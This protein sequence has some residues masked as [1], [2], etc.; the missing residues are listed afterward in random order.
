MKINT[1]TS[2]FHILLIILISGIVF[3]NTF[4]NS[5]VYD[6]KVFIVNNES[7]KSL[8]N[9]P[10]FFISAK[11]FSGERNF[12]V[13]RPVATLSFAIDYFLWGLNPVGYHIPN[14]L[15]HTLNAILLYFLVR[16]ILTT[17]M[18]A[19][20]ASLL[21][22]THPV[23]TEAVTWI[24]GRSNV[25]FLF[26]FLLAF[27]FYLKFVGFEIKCLEQTSNSRLYYYFGA[28]VFFILSLLS[29]ETAIIFPVILILYDNFLIPKKERKEVLKQGQ[30]YLPFWGVSGLYILLRFTVLGRISQMGF[31]GGGLY[32][33]ILTMCRA[34]VYYIKLILLPLKLSIDYPF[35][36]STSFFELPVI[37]SIVGLMFILLLGIKVN[38]YSREISFGIFWFFIGLM[39]VSNLVPLRALV[40]ERFL[41]LPSIGFCIVVS[42]LLTKLYEFNPRNETS[43]LARGQLKYF[44]K[45]AVVFFILILCFYSIRT[46]IRNSDWKNNYN[47]WLSMVKS[48]PD[49]PK[50]HYALGDIYYKE[51]NYDQAL[52]E[53]KKALELNQ[54]F[55]EIYN[56]VGLIY[57]QK[58]LY[59]E[60]LREYE[61]AL[62]MSCIFDNTYIHIHNNMGNAYTRMNLYNKAI[63]Q[64]KKALEL[65]PNYPQAH[66]N[67]G[68]IYH[69][70]GRFDEATKEY[71]KVVKLS[72]DFTL[73]RE[74][75]TELKQNLNATRYKK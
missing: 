25:L 53:F 57:E 65:N 27:Y 33:T 69:K 36:I 12:V 30:Y 75:L 58:G 72:P 34:F 40:A 10:Q 28:I 1:N 13:Y 46:I 4:R 29:K 15:F 66:F 45:F 41:Y 71:E 32:P 42:V 18:T 24:S 3:F 48:S 5:F 44:K 19:F 70:Q 50:A 56:N 73:V 17:K 61:K 60:A 59:N 52:E 16:L 11:S 74:K 67:L 6:D 26:F 14:F 49:S 51:G 62:K 22:I 35:S 64:Y 63:L 31:W 47:L 7:I 21:F 39:P 38:K 9:I 68:V 54:N 43:P 37:I 20:F 8:K 55:A 23:Q 2:G